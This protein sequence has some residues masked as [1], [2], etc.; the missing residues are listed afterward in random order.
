MGFPS[1]HNPT[2]PF[3]SAATTTPSA[4]SLQKETKSETGKGTYRVVSGWLVSAGLAG[5]LFVIDLLSP[6]GYAVCMLYA[7][8]ILLTRLIPDLQSTMIMAGT[9]ISLT[10]AGAEL[11]P[12]AIAQHDN[13]NRVIA[14]ALLLGISWILVTQKQSARRVKAAQQAMR[15]SEERL[16]LFIEH[17]PVALAMFDRGMRYLAVSRRWITD[18]G[19][20]DRDVIGHGHYEL[21]PDVPDRWK[22]VHRRGLA[23]EIVREG[24]DRVEGADGSEQWL[25]WEVR[26]W[27]TGDGRVGGVIIFTEDITERK[28]DERLLLRHQEELRGQQVQL[29]ELTAKLLWAQEQ[30]RKRIARDLHDD[31]TQRLAALT[32]DLQRLSLQ[33]SESG[34]SYSSLLEQMGKK[35]EQLTTEL[36]HLAHQL[37]PSLLEHAGLE[38]AICEC[39]EEFS[40]RTGLTTEIV[41]REVPAAIPL[42]QATCLYRI[43]QESLQNVRKHAKAAN[44]VVRLLRARNGLELCIHDD[45]RGFDRPEDAAPPK[46]L[47]LTS[48]AERVKTLHGTFH[49]RSKVGHGTEIHAWV[50]LSETGSDR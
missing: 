41:V 13:S 3:P 12:G 43:L 37:H 39:V 24:E 6:L 22:A 10:W 28:K 49:V 42:A 38:A 25:C 19:L 34:A 16:R 47:G 17:A 33:T 48:M 20:S 18:Y 31:F 14:T 29:Q 40:T 11:S 21:F 26:P 7:L 45:G 50:P 32:I 9:T 15:E 30:E 5:A 44:I 2:T 4:V 35:T 36:Q 27:H 46:G 23:G 8:P 1:P